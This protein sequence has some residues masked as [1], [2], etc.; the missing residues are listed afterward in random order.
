M[1]KYTL[2]VILGSLPFKLD[3]SSSSSQH[4]VP[5]AFRAFFHPRASQINEPS[6]TAEHAA[7]PSTIISPPPTLATFDSQS[8]PHAPDLPTLTPPAQVEHG[9]ISHADL[10][11]LHNEQL[12]VS[13]FSNADEICN[14]ENIVE[15]TLFPGDPDSGDSGKEVQDSVPENGVLWDYLSKL[16]RSVK[17]QI[18]VHHKPAVYSSGT[19]WHRPRDPIFALEAARISSSGITPRELYHMDV[20]IWILGLK[21]RLP[22]EPEVLHC[23]KCSGHLSQS[24]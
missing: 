5:G 24:G 7:P 1:C 8:Q 16:L 9:H 14:Q 18:D 22:G 23:P 11:R 21:A 13:E 17:G 19:F 15:D 4:H 2:D 20:F 10:E 6:P 12:Y 3:Q